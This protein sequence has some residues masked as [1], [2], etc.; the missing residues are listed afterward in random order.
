MINAQGSHR[1]APGRGH[2]GGVAVATPPTVPAPLSFHEEQTL[3]APWPVHDP[4]VVDTPAAPPGPAAAP[5]GGG[6]RTGGR[7]GARRAAHRRKA[8]A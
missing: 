8:P 1:A 7:A 4:T 5:G 6:P 3:V 2:A